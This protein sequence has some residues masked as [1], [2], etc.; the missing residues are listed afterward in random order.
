[1]LLVPD[2]LARLLCVGVH[3]L[4][5]SQAALVHASLQHRM[6][7]TNDTTCCRP[8][9]DVDN[10]KYMV[11]EH[12]PESQTWQ[13]TQA[14]GD[15]SS[16]CGFSRKTAGLLL[17]VV[18]VLAI[19]L[20]VGLG[21][22]L[23]RG[24]GSPSPSPPSSPAPPPLDGPTPA[25]SGGPAAAPGALLA[26]L[27]AQP[28]PYDSAPAPAPISPPLAPAPEPS[29]NAASPAPI[30]AP[31]PEPS[32]S[33]LA[34]APGPLAAAAGRS[35]AAGAAAP[36][37]AVSRYNLPHSLLGP[38]ACVLW[39]PTSPHVSAGVSHHGHHHGHR[40]RKITCA[41]W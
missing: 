4:M 1:M 36:S 7:L 21:V 27:A 14:K 30:P 41:V 3:M 10:P 20:G 18:A 17:L 31:A 28:E 6:D 19:G 24:C 37:P 5:K 13:H 35:E 9:R 15:S 32:D 40:L 11:Q 38:H 39:L 16:I 29:E 23:P 34:P 2:M 8:P 22:G 12:D 25:P 33:A 26:P